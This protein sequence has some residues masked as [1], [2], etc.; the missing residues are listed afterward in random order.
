MQIRVNQFLIL[1]VKMHR[2]PIYVCEHEFVSISVS[3]FA[4]D[5]SPNKV[6]SHLF[7]RSV[8]VWMLSIFEHKLKSHTIYYIDS[9]FIYDQI[10]EV[11]TTSSVKC[12]YSC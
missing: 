2:E 1:R 10:F 9:V 6:N 8:H 7:Q 12:Y 5:P 4:K 3:V 11:Q